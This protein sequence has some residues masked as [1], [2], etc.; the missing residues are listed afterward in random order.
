[1]VLNQAARTDSPGA[2]AAT[3][4]TA[5]RTDASAHAHRQSPSSAPNVTTPRVEKA[6]EE[7]FWRPRGADSLT[8]PDRHGSKRTKSGR[9]QPD[10]HQVLCR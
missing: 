9:L 10:L 2:S 4:G 7:E 5:P 6:E 1:M 3:V 8:C